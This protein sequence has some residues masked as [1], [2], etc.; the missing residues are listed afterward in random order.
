MRILTATQ[1]APTAC[2]PTVYATPVIQVA[3]VHD[4]RTR[5]ERVSLHVPLECFFTTCTSDKPLNK[6]T[7]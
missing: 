4:E 1:A 7:V 2:A 3:Q 6:K 5:K